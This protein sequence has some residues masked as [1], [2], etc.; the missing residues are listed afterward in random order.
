MVDDMVREHGCRSRDAAGSDTGTA[1]GFDRSG[2]RAG[3]W[4]AAVLALFTVGALGPVNSARAVDSDVTAPTVVSVAVSTTSV[5]VSSVPGYVRI[6]ARVRDDGMGVDRVGFLLRSSIPSQI[7]TCGAN[8]KAGTINDGTWSC[9]VTVKVGA[10]TGLW[11]LATTV[12]DKVNNT[13]YVPSSSTAV[14]VGPGGAISEQPLGYQAINPKR[15][16]D[17]RDGTGITA[18]K[19]DA[20]GVV[21]LDLRSVGVLPPEAVTAA[22]LNVTVTEPERPGFLTAYPCNQ[23][24]PLA[25]NVNYSAGQTVPN[26]VTVRAD[27][28]G[29]V[30]LYSSQRTHLVADAFGA[31]F[32][33]SS[34]LYTPLTPYRLI[35]TRDSSS[36]HPGK[37]LPG[38]PLAV[39]VAGLGGVPDRLTQATNPVLVNITV[40][41]PEAAGYLTAW[42]D[43]RSPRPATSNLNFAPGQTIPNLASVRVGSLGSICVYLSS[44]A[45]VIVDVVGY[46]SDSSSI[47]GGSQFAGLRPTRILDTRDGTGTPAPSRLHAG[48]TLTLQVS[49]RGGALVGAR[50]AV[51]NVTVTEPL[52]AGY[53]TAYPCDASRPLASNLN[54]VPSQTVPNL[55][56]TGLDGDGRACLYASA[57]THLV[58]D[59]AGAFYPA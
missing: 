24:R 38:S 26:L 22:V 12:A 25:S 44:P 51:I 43:C 18:G 2:R 10:A 3:R 39:P 42:V 16:L 53:V 33:N 49:G 47:R 48:E 4:T 27:L 11:T 56:V 29:V 40:T 1:Y 14:M 54:F 13:A 15:V 19:V 28:S 57:D 20:E 34:Y 6:T 7:E 46:Y 36:S 9:A 23:S 41:E 32:P 59:L 35:D 31:Y 55:V 50:A 8:L 45:H 52:A 30:C 37:V 5:D 17:T 58:A 21:R